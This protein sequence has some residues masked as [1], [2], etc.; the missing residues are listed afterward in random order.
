MPHPRYLEDL[1]TSADIVEWLAY[2]NEEPFGPRHDD[3]RI[4]QLTALL[5]NVNRG[6][7]QQPMKWDDWFPSCEKLEEVEQAREKAARPDVQADN[8]IAL[9][10]AFNK[11]FYEKE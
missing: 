1:L 11:R 7:D 3:F 5:F 8:A 9:F 2:A 6:K 4:G 10:K